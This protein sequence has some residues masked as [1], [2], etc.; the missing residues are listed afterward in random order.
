MVINLTLDVLI[1]GAVL[2]MIGLIIA[3]LWNGQK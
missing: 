1:L 2:I 3:L